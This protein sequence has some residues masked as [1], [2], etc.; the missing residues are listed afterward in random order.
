MRTSPTEALTY[1][2]HCSLLSLRGPRGPQ[3]GRTTE[4]ARQSTNVFTLFATGH[5]GPRFKDHLHRREQCTTSM[6]KIY[7]NQF[8]LLGFSVFPN[9]EHRSREPSTLRLTC[10]L[11]TKFSH[12]ALPILRGQRRSD[13][14]SLRAS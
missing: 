9:P 4:S 10:K 14:K 8:N 3:I 5:V 1:I 13:T 7:P 6:R 12:L 2:N 11:L